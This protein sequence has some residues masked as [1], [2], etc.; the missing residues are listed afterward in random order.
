M[1]P[2]VLAVLAFGVSACTLTNPSTRQRDPDD[3]HAVL[4]SPVV[5]TDASLAPSDPPGSVRF[6]EEPLR[7]VAGI[8]SG[9]TWLLELYQEASAAKEELARRLGT[10]ELAL[11][12]SKTTQA[13]LSTDH[14]KLT[15][16]CNE[17]DQRVRELE[18][19]TLDLARRLAASEIVRLE[20]QKA[21]LERESRSD[22]KERP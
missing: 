4:M 12:D 7:E 21:D 22:R 2:Y 20:A 15:T 10:S 8:S 19:Q 17:L 14:A 11:A 5:V 9:R 3:D 18:A 13:V 6:V 16:R 1:K